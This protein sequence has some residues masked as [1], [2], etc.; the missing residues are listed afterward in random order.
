MSF[1]KKFL[2]I[3]QRYRAG[4]YALAGSFIIAFGWG[5]YHL[6]KHIVWLFILKVLGLILII[7]IFYQLGKLT[8][9]YA[10][11]LF[12]RHIFWHQEFS[13]FLDELFFVASLFF[14]IFFFKK[15]ILSVAYV[16]LLLPVLF[17]RI[18]YYLKRHPE[19]SPW[20]R[21][22]KSIFILCYFTFLTQVLC[23]YFA[24]R[25][26]I[27]DAQVKYFN[28]VI[29]RSVAMTSFW[30]FGFAI[31]SLLYW[32]IKSYI[33]Y[34]FILLWSS[35]F[36][37]A[38]MLWIVNIGILYYSGLYFSP[39]ALDH[40]RGGEGVVNNNIAYLLIASLCIIGIIFVFVVRD[41]IKA[42]KQTPKRYWYYYNTALIGIAL[43]CILGLSSF[44]STPE[45]L[46]VKSFYNRYFGKEEIIVLPNELQKKLER[47]GL[48]YDLDTFKVS[49]HETVFSSSTQKLLPDR[50][51]KDRP[52]IVIV[53]LESFSARL[54]S[55]YNPRFAALTPGMTKMAQDKNVTI[56]R[57]YYN[58]STPTITGTLSQLCSFLPPFGHNEIQ[59]ERKLQNHHLLCLP[60]ILKKYGGYEYATYITAVD[61]EFSHKDG[62][63]TSMGVDKI[64]G[65]AEL[66]KYISEP[67]LSWGYSDHQLFPVTLK[68]MNEQR[69]QPFLI[70]LSTVDTHPPFNLAKDEIKYGN[71][72]QPVLNS[73]HT[74]DD[75]FLKFWEDFTHSPFYDNTIVVAVADHAIFPAALTKDLFPEEAGTLSYYDQNLFMMYVP[76]SVL[77]KEVTTLSSGLDF[78]P[79]LLH[80]LDINTSNSFEGH[81]IFDDREKYPNIVGMHE[82][83]LYINQLVD[84]QKRKID[85]DVPDN[86]ECSFY[87]TVSSTQPLT[88]CEFLH[89][90]RWKRQMFERGRL[91]ENLH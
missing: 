34:F 30:L 44:K 70:M 57:N 87:E 79:T 45:H 69:E 46:I 75:A 27:L 23:Q 83:G 11:K 86:L 68:F 4:G 55:I 49:H 77:P 17:W 12:K 1:F 14:I 89:F 18:H 7:Y 64:F 8:Y 37:F 28:I 24:Y 31:A 42:H 40:L 72:T 85:Y 54:T 56:F 35:I 80:I 58:A 53:F 82:L 39:T 5:W 26:Y 91:W 38:M 67:P 3:L 51:L 25:Y 90:Y 41:I 9:I 76:G 48:F 81:S 32:Q 20:L 63:F 84:K 22:N 62:I 15:E 73:F 66:K 74:T 65:T 60:D 10:V 2:F 52:N 33:R 47:F 88:M 61:K 59:N 19:A 29:F 78:T 71:G 50:F 36:V 43:V 6:N 13:L 16:S 21:V